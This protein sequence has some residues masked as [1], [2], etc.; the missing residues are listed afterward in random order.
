MNYVKLNATTVLLEPL[1][2]LE[3]DELIDELL[4]GAEVDGVLRARIRDRAEG[5]PLFVEEMLAMLR[6]AGD[7]LVDV[8]PTIQ[9]LL[10]ARI[11][12]LDAADRGVLERGAV[13]GRVFHAGAVQAL[14]P[15]SRR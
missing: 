1:S 3:T 9:A 10:A 8:P 13:E 14:A 2:A 12:Q 15:A 5:N 7:V 6:D 4:A 11:D